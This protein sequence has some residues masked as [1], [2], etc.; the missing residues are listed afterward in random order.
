M[1]HKAIFACNL[2]WYFW[3]RAMLSKTSQW[4]CEYGPRFILLTLFIPLTLLRKC[5]AM[6]HRVGKH[7]ET[8]V[9]NI[10]KHQMFLNSLGNIFASREA[11]FVSATMFPRVGKQGNIWG[12]IENHECFHNNVSTTMFPIVCRGLKPR[13]NISNIFDPTMWD[14]NF[15]Q[16]QT[17]SNLSHHYPT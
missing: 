4:N 11:N 2:Q 17:Q 6:F 14:E 3:H 12:N 7:W 1:S 13:S 15:K 5:F 16:S 10:G 9:R 8:L